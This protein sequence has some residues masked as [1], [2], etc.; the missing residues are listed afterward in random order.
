MAVLDASP[1][2]YYGRI[3]RLRWLREFYGKLVT[4]PSVVRET[5]DEAKVLGKPGV[6]VIE[7]AFRERV[8]QVHGLAEEENDLASRVAELE[9]IEI[10]DYED[11][12]KRFSEIEVLSFQECKYKIVLYHGSAIFPRGDPPQLASLA[13]KFDAKVI[14]TGH[15]HAPAL[16]SFE[17][18]VIIN[19]GSAT[20]CLGGSWNALGIPSFSFVR[21]ESTSVIGK[22]YIIQDFETKCLTEKEFRI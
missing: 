3:G 17:D 11:V 15:T 2:I 9:K 18:V 20:G 16:K 10:E 12:I 4:T 7:E 14:V 19:P 1:I 5:V 13:K 8:L 21:F 6:S 22:I